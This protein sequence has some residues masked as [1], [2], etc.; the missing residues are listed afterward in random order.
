[1]RKWMLLL[2]SLSLLLCLQPQCP[3]VLSAQDTPAE[4][5][6]KPDKPDRPFVENMTREEAEADI[7]RVLR[8]DDEDAYERIN[9][10]RLQWVPLLLSAKYWRECVYWAHELLAE[11]IDWVRKR[12]RWEVALYGC[13]PDDIVARYNDMKDVFDASAPQLCRAILALYTLGADAQADK[14][15][16]TAPDDPWVRAALAW[17]GKL[18]SAEACA[19]AL[20]VVLPSYMDQLNDHYINLNPGLLDEDA[21]EYAVYSSMYC[22]LTAGIMLTPDGVIAFPSFPVQWAAARFFERLGIIVT[23]D[24]RPEFRNR[25]AKQIEIVCGKRDNYLAQKQKFEAAPSASSSGGPVTGKTAQLSIGPQ[26]LQYARILPGN[27]EYPQLICAISAFQGSPD[28]PQAQQYL[29][30]RLESYGDRL[31]ALLAARMMLAQRDDRRDAVIS[32]ARWLR[33]SSLCNDVAAAFRTALEQGGDDLAPLAQAMAGKADFPTDFRFAPLNLRIEQRAALVNALAGEDERKAYGGAVPLYW[34]NV[35]MARWS[36][37]NVLG[38]LEAA[39]QSMDADGAA[40]GWK[41]G[42]QAA[43]QAHMELQSMSPPRKMPEMLK[44]FAAEHPKSVALLQAVWD[45]IEAPDKDELA[46]LEWAALAAQYS[47]GKFV[48]LSEEQEK[49]L[50]EDPHAGG[51]WGR[52]MLGMIAGASG[53][54]IRRDELIALGDATCPIDRLCVSMRMSSNDDFGHCRSGNWLAQEH[55]TVRGALLAPLQADQIAFIGS[56]HAA[57]GKGARGA[58]ALVRLAMDR[59]VTPYYSGRFL[60]SLGHMLFSRDTIAEFVVMTMNVY[61]DLVQDDWDVAAKNVIRLT[62]FGQSVEWNMGEIAL[63]TPPGEYIQTCVERELQSN[64]DDVNHLLNM[65]HAICGGAPYRALELVADAEKLGVSQYGRFVAGQMFIRASAATGDFE[66]AIKRYRDMRD[67]EVGYPAYLDYFLL[68]G[69]A[70]GNDWKHIEEALKEVRAREP[71]LDDPRTAVGL[72][73]A[74][75]AAGLYKEAAKLKMPAGVS[76]GKVAFRYGPWSDIFYAARA[77][78]D[79]GKFNDLAR[80][81]NTYYEKRLPFSVG[82]ALDSALIY[83]ICCKLS[84]QLTPPGL[85]DNGLLHVFDKKASHYLA[86]SDGLLD[87][88]AMRIL[89]GDAKP[90]SLPQPGHDWV[91]HGA[92]FAERPSFDRGSGFIRAGEVDARDRFVRGIISWLCGDDD[93]AR[94]LLKE[95]MDLDQ[96]FSHEYHVAD[97]LLKNH[98]KKK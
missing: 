20:I 93:T 62:R 10:G 59:P 24:G 39:L 58:G 9:K 7:A 61:G 89:C 68:H 98:L 74:Y 30:D 2:V 63:V 33:N 71:D 95:C 82:M 46:K 83:A 72:R 57:M 47:A 94:T 48:E 35:A 69:M 15:V 64:S 31:C 85:D 27:Y 25:I 34:M 81:S 1:M 91:W 78:L 36:Q 17:L 4:P 19:N 51:G 65:S 21:G 42:C 44:G 26:M 41:N 79:A 60:Y 38:G 80:D 55:L 43:V 12:Q 49:L 22:E 32:V 87:Q 56:V 13:D 96:R 29:L 8:E 53:D 14:L 76:E 90:D 86:Q 3:F 37:L 66:G 70:E 73:R 6:A 28:W 92:R 5:E 11:E 75:M 18:E 23:Q 40:N 54:S 50:L 84:P 88:Q 97:Y 52:V 16:K 45:M 77:Q 67:E